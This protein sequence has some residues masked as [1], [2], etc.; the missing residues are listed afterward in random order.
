M[1]GRA[2][3][4]LIIA[5][6]ALRNAVINRSIFSAVVFMAI[7]SSITTPLLMRL[8]ASKITTPAKS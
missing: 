5:E 4:E 3:V 2:A 7:L 8:M 1:N 6:I